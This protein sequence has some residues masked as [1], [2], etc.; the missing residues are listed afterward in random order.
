M[1]LSALLSSSGHTA[2]AAAST[3]TSSVLRQDF[4]LSP[5][6]PPA[7]ALELLATSLAAAGGLQQVHR[8]RAQAVHR[9]IVKGQHKWN[10]GSA[11]SIS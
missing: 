11:V 8:G 6:L 5:E 4:S 3:I 1:A 7:L 9:K 10:W 2:H